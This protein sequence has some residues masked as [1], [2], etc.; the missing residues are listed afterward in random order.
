MSDQPATDCPPPPELKNEEKAS[1]AAE[2]AKAM[3]VRACEM[4]QASFTAN[5]G[6]SA[7]AV[8]STEME[9]TYNQSSTVG[10]E[11]L[12]INAS[13][14]NQSQQNITCTINKSSMKTNINTKAGNSIT[15]DAGKN[16]DIDCKDGFNIKQD[17]N[18]ES[19]N[20][21]NLTSETVTSIANQTKDT[22][23]KTLDTIQKS[24]TGLGATPAGQ[25]AISDEVVNINNVDYGKLVNDTL[26]EI[27][28]STDAQNNITFKAGG[29]V[30]IKGNNCNLDQ[31]LL[32]KVIANSVLSDAYS[33]AFSN[34]SE[35]INESDTKMR[36][37]NEA[38]GAESLKS[39]GAYSPAALAKALGNIY[40]WLAII[41]AVGGGI[42]LYIKMSGDKKKNPDG[43]DSG[44]GYER[45]IN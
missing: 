31:S 38:K 16:I 7:F 43:S 33:Q 1:K 34:I 22:V 26:K 6:A 14:Y 10:C 25:K 23:K 13:E 30:T 24:T 32:L 35:K 29:N 5:F 28:I 4:S 12:M 39:F 21:I 2:I 37:E 8:M 44:S 20:T 3:G 41:G 9:V 40:I 15:F 42:F 45:L 11:S 19:V 36:Q 27:N 17:L 18:L